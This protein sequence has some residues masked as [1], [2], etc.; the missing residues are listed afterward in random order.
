MH[1][2]DMYWIVMPSLHHD[3]VVLSWMDMAGFIGMGGLFMWYFL[4]KY[5]THS[6]VPVNDP[7]LDISIQMKN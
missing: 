6:L 1:W 5:T 2:L 7:R 4:N 3:G